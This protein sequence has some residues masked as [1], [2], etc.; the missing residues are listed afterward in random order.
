MSEKIREIMKKNKYPFYV[1][2]AILS[3]LLVV[4]IIILL[5][6]RGYADT[7]LV[8]DVTKTATASGD[9]DISG[10]GRTY[11][12]QSNNW[13]KGVKINIT[14]D[15]SNNKVY[16]VFENTTIDVSGDAPAIT[17]N[18]EQNPV[19]KDNYYSSDAAEVLN[20]NTVDVYLLFKGD[21]KLSNASVSTQPLIKAENYAYTLSKARQGSMPNLITEVSQYVHYGQK[22]N[23]HIN[24]Y[25]MYKENSVKAGNDKLT[26]VNNGSGAA[27][28]TPANTPFRDML[29]AE[30]IRN[31]NDVTESTGTWPYDGTPYYTSG[32]FLVGQS[33]RGDDS[34]INYGP[35]NVTIDG[36]SISITG[37]GNGAG[38]GNGAY[39]SSDIRGELTD[40]CDIWM[41]DVWS[42]STVL[43]PVEPSVEIK[44][45]TVSV[46]MKGNGS[47]FVNN[48]LNGATTAA[49]DGKVTITGGSVYLK[50]QDKDTTV[51]P[52]TSA[53]DK[54]GQQLYL[55]TAE[56]TTDLPRAADLGTGII[57]QEFALN[58]IQNTEVED[59]K[60]SI[61]KIRN[62]VDDGTYETFNGVSDIN[63]MSTSVTL[64]SRLYKFTGYLHENEND[65]AD[66]GKLYF[67][68]PA[69]RFESYELTID[70]MLSGATYNKAI[71]NSSMKGNLESYKNL[72]ADQYSVY[73]SSN[74]NIK[75]TKSVLLKITGIPAYCESVTSTYQQANGATGPCDVQ[76]DTATGDWYICTDAAAADMTIF[77]NYR[78]GQYTIVYDYG[79]TDADRLAGKISEINNANN[80]VNYVST[81]TCGEAYT[82]QD[83]SWDNHIFAGWVTEDGNPITDIPSSTYNSKDATIKVYAKWKCTVTYVIG[84]GLVSFIPANVSSLT[85]SLSTDNKKYTYEVDYNGVNDRFNVWDKAPAK[86]KD[87]FSFTV[88]SN[89]DIYDF[90]GWNYDNTIY[91]TD[92]DIS[93]N[94]NVEI[95]AEFERVGYLIHINAIYEGNNASILTYAS[96][97][98][99]DYS[100]IDPNNPGTWIPRTDI[101]SGW[102]T[103]TDENQ[104]VTAVGLLNS[105]SKTVITVNAKP[106]YEITEGRVINGSNTDIIRP[107]SEG[108]ASDGITIEKS[109]TAQKQDIY[110]SIVFRLKEYEIKY[111]DK[112]NGV[113]VLIDGTAEDSSKNPVSYTIES[114]VMEFA[115]PTYVDKPRNYQFVGFKMLGRENE[116]AFTTLDASTV[117]GELQLIAQWEE[118]QLYDIN[119]DSVLTNVTDDVLSGQEYG[120]VEAYSGSDRVTS[121]MENENIKLK[122]TIY[123]GVKL[124]KV[125][126]TY[127]ES[128]GTETVR[129][130]RPDVLGV[131]P[132][133]EYEIDFTM[134]AAPIDIDVEFSAVEYMIT[135]L[136]LH[137]A[138]NDNPMTYTVFDDFELINPSMEGWT[139]EKWQLITPNDDTLDDDTD[140]KTTDIDRISHRTGNL[141][142]YAKWVEEPETPDVLHY[143]TVDEG[144]I[145]G[146]VLLSKTSALKN[147]YIFVN[148]TGAK[149]YKLTNIVYNPSTQASTARTSMF[150]RLLDMRTSSIDFSANQVAE[151]VYYFIMPDADV[152]ITAVFEPIVYSITYDAQGGSYENT[153]EYTVEDEITLNPATKEDQRFLGWYDQAGNKVEKI[154]NNIGNISL[155]A[156][157]E[158][159]AAV[160][161]A[162][163]NPDNSSDNNVPD[164]Q[165]NGGNTDVSDNISNGG[166]GNN[167]YVDGGIQT[168]DSN[169]IGKLIAV[170]VLCAVILI[171]I[172][173][174]RK[175]KDEQDSEN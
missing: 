26:L 111:Y 49:K 130:I 38:I 57:G 61:S 59:Y 7:P 27:I 172:I 150:A 134:P 133:V 141:M 46:V 94:E 102:G 11:L 98:T 31:K 76:Y 8:V 23:L 106:G 103:T 10:D 39:S 109:V 173:P 104:Y 55:F 91:D 167:N 159:N 6:P 36:G 162:P 2:A 129:T 88:E 166:S 142:I 74:N 48:A 114:G 151:G 175:K 163:E 136:N 66:R 146:E 70:S 37:K 120:K 121:A 105:T 152:E 140:V 35:A 43:T 45:G 44:N 21:C 96:S 65:G 132:F 52:Y 122:V 125:V 117:T 42:T 115:R 144:I 54:L 137:S 165:E 169:N 41:N 161:P 77:I 118:R 110:I 53:Y 12:V 113:S 100:E 119:I 86:T 149:G 71:V 95:K 4:S 82:L 47:C 126:S 90:I 73:S 60:Y 69:E 89:K 84:D 160:N 63:A 170:C 22:I 127:T 138:A 72:A 97:A 14:P 155:V 107:N 50:R 29:Y 75:Q 123:K 51:Y 147:E 164:D 154:V 143:A 158:S 62:T 79:L 34:T 135:Y 145:N 124:D 25:D 81:H 78:M 56:Y 20:K 156:K 40:C 128:N 16:V 153:E 32:T 157:W 93:V 3:C 108:R 99:L 33:I 17:I 168:G 80:P 68:L 112:E 92:R 171:L 18:V 101:V 15:G 64:P 9:V 85:G 28:G 131:E 139:F 87:E 19:T 1:G 148:V 58:N 67:Y 83:A 30:G 13:N 24:S 174:K 5:M 116:Q